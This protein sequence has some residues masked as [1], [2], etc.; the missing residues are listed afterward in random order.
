MGRPTT[1]RLGSNTSPTISVTQMNVDFFTSTELNPTNFPEWLERIAAFD[2]D[3][4]TI[5][6]R[7]YPGYTTWPLD[8]VRQRAWPSLDAVLLRR[9]SANTLSTTFPSRRVLSRLLVTAHAITGAGDRGPVPS[10]GGLQCLELYPIA[11]EPSWLPSGAYHYDRAAN[12]LSQI[13]PFANRADWLKLVP[14]LATAKGGSFLLVLAGDYSRARS[15]YGDRALRFLFLEAGHLA[16]NVC[17]IATSLNYCALPLGG[18]FEQQI[19]SHL[20]LPSGDQVLSVLL[21][22]KP[23]RMSGD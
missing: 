23:N 3:P 12:H 19:A 2:A 13:V 4:T 1:Q 5:K 14:S 15:K 22:G 17:L 16:Q 18:I 21:C 20:R 7:S 11:L 10:A 6:A 8:R 9:R